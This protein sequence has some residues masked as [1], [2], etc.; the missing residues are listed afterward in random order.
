MSLL[1]TTLPESKPKTLHNA[2]PFLKWAGGK[3]QLIPAIKEKLP[4]AFGEGKTFEGRYFEPFVGGGAL[5]FSLAPQLKPGHS[6]ISD[7]NGEL[8]Y[9]FLSVRD[10]LDA[11]IEKLAEY[12]RDH[13]TVRGHDH[14]KR[15]ELYYSVRKL[16]RQNNWAIPTDDPEKIVEHGAPTSF[17]RHTAT[18]SGEPKAALCT[19]K[20]TWFSTTLSN[21]DT[22]SS[23]PCRTPASG[24]T[25]L[26]PVSKSGTRTPP[27]ETATTRREGVWCPGGKSARTSRTCTSTSSEVRLFRRYTDDVQKRGAQHCLNCAP[28][29]RL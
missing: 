18:S 20:L 3:T 21:R 26:E 6:F 14:A 24:L 22:S 13:S 2:K 27:S 16:D 9:T 19:R 7:T 11:L 23:C 28:S 8:V 15:K 17:S 25:V 5:F 4:V 10:H 29:L 1:P 12:E